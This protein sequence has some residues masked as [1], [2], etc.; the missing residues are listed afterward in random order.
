MPLIVH[1][2]A[3]PRAIH[4]GTARGRP[5]NSGSSNIL[6]GNEA[7]LGSGSQNIYLGANHIDSSGFSNESNHI[8]IGPDQYSI[9]TTAQ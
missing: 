7:D 3:D 8:R 6:I 1:H 2:H 4:A 9:V 5:S